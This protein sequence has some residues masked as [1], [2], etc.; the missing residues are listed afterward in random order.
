MTTEPWQCAGW[1]MVKSTGFGFELLDDLRVR[2]GTDEERIAE[3]V[4][5]LA[6]TCA[7][8]RFLEA[9]LLSSRTAHDQLRGGLGAGWR[10]KDRRK[11]LVAAMYLQRF[12]AKNESTSFFGPVY[13]APVGGT[14]DVRFD[15]GAGGPP[16]LETQWTHWAAQAV[17]DAMSADPEVLP[18]IRPRIPANLVR[19]G[20]RHLS[21]RYGDWPIEVVELEGPCTDLGRRILA[22]CDGVATP[23]GIAESVGAELSTVVESLAELARRGLVTCH[24]QVPYG[25][26]DPLRPLIDFAAELPDDT[27]STVLTDL[28]AHRHAVHAAHATPDRPAVL[29]AADAAFTAL[30]GSPAQRNAGR[31]YADRTILIE[32]GHFAWTDLTLGGPVHGYLR[33]EAPIVLDLLFEL[34]LERRRRR[35]RAVTAWFTDTF[36]TAVVPL[37]QVIAAADLREQLRALDDTCRADGP[38]AITDL[39]LA[40][41]DR[42]RVEVDLD[43]ARHHAAR[44]DFDTWSVAGADLFIDARGVA[45]L[46]AD[47]FRVVVGEV[48]GLHDQLLQG[49]WPALHPCRADFEA[50]IGK[51]VAGL[52]DGRICDP[53]L[54]HGR[55]TLAR[56]EVLPEVEFLGRSPRGPGEVCRAADLVVRLDGGL[57]V[58]E[59]PTLGRVHLTRPPTYSW[60]AE[61]ES[62]FSPFCGARL[63]G[64]EDMFRTL[65]GHAHLPRLTIGRTV[66]HRETWRVPPEPRPWTSLSPR[67]QAEVRALRERLG[68]PDQVYARF[69]GEPK[70]VFVDFDIPVLVDLFARH[71]ARATGPTVITEMLPGPTGLWLRDHDGRH[72]GEL[73]F[74][75]YRRQG[76]R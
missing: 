6:R 3:C 55:K 27:W 25:L 75:Y 7:D 50:E 14:E 28:D 32:D 71:H 74:G 18:H 61:V 21:V 44:I 40:D 10:S 53:V 13:W 4:R 72:T 36:G 33:D 64:A 56:A 67:N 54:A 59:S 22:H 31:H 2:T 30:T 65:D 60:D 58:L 34:S 42:A 5:R 41:T 17:A 29:D 46:D 23:A 38:S 68:L 39:L 52:A 35:V 57:L 19:R 1:A 51:L 63:I 20:D 69:Q 11:V 26:L 16:T 43:R 49:L 62:V 24:V 37:D 73:R 76:R 48:H 9:V 70:P 15:P 66:V 12:C 45:D 8:P 47:D